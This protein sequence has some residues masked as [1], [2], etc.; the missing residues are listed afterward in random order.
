M[1]FT[2][3][4]R[5]PSG[6][7]RALACATHLDSLTARLAEPWVQAVIEP[8]CLRPWGG[9]PH[10]RRRV[11]RR[12]EYGRDAVPGQL[13]NSS[14]IGADAV[15]TPPL[16]Q[17]RRRP[18]GRRAGRASGFPMSGE[19]EDTCFRCGRSSIFPVQQGPS[20]RPPGIQQA[21]R[22]ATAARAT[23]RERVPRRS[24]SVQVAARGMCIR[25]KALEYVRPALG[26]VRPASGAEDRASCRPARRF[27]HRPRRLRP[28]AWRSLL[29]RPTG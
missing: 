10:D 14:R 11:Q 18:F 28:R 5:S 22:H 3:R 21:I 25:I 15:I 19:G 2:M 8:I 1:P 9:L 12:R 23:A 16:Q 26:R 27:R 13:R 20:S 4:N 6:H 17:P 24:P 7:D 29:R